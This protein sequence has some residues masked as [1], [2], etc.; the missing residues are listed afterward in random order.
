MSL[1][2]P[3][4]IA[5]ENHYKQGTKPSIRMA[6]ATMAILSHSKYLYKSHFLNF[7]LHEDMDSASK[8]ICM[9][10]MNLM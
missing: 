7:V 10:H 2:S 9:T 3:S 4:L 5:Q 8:I 1:I 6:I